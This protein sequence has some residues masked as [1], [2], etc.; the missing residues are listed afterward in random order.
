MS[1][2]KFKQRI[3][4]KLY[5]KT[6]IIDDYEKKKKNAV[7]KDTKILNVV[8]TQKTFSFLYFEFYKI[9]TMKIY[10]SFYA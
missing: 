1:L 6:F 10:Y 8:K 2:S 7:E 3:F 5:S 4:Y 9:S